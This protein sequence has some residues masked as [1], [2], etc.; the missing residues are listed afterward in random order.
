VIYCKSIDCNSD[1]GTVQKPFGIPNVTH[2]ADLS[3]TD[4]LIYQFELYFPP[5]SSGL[6][7]V[8]VADGGF[9]VWPSEP[10]EWFYGDNTLISFP[11]RYYIASPEHKF[12]VWYYNLD[13]TYNHTFTVRIGQVS[14]T[15]FIS[16]FI[17]GFGQKPIEEVMAEMAAQ[18]EKEKESR[19][20]DIEDYFA[21]EEEVTVQ[22]NSD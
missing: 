13:D 3:V 15:L 1:G 16:S 8:R 5:G 2:D 19:L 21:L 20:K 7:Y 6:L 22:E 10:G 11:D 14:S 17:P 4:G 9:P 18:Q 12:K